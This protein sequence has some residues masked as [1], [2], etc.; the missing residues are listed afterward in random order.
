MPHIEVLPNTGA[1][2]APGWAY[3]PDTGYD[4]S[5]VAIN[6]KDRKRQ[7]QRSGNIATGLELSARQLTAVQRRI[8]E[9][10]R[11]NDARSAIEVPGRKSAWDPSYYTV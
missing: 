1:A 5:K 8:V 2:P 11:D 10:E 6:P 7:A 4:P 9:L 3:V